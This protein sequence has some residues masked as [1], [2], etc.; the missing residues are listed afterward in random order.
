MTTF[1]LKEVTSDLANAPIATPVAYDLAVAILLD[2]LRRAAKPAPAD[3]TFVK[4]RKDP[5]FPL[6]QEQMCMLGWFLTVSDS[7]RQATES[8]WDVPDPIAQLRKLRSDTAPLTA[9]MM[10][11]NA[12][13]QEEFL[14]RWAQCIGLT[15]DGEDV[16]TSAER[17]VYLDYR[18]VL[19][20]YAQAE[21]ARL[22]EE[23]SRQA[24]IRKAEEER[25]ATE[26]RGW[27]E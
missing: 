19:R 22:K 1:P 24:A 3:G 8:G 5:D 14:R 17:V 25:R 15:I 21:D 7:L 13:R 6:W 2:T 4:W 16:T 11:S 27:R 12:F 23:E 26:A 18:V 9:E 20:E 10:R